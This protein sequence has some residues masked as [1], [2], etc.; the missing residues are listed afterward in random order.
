MQV[1]YV[2]VQIVLVLAVL[3]IIIQEAAHM[4]IRLETVLQTIIVETVQQEMR[5]V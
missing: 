1:K 2:I 4:I 3:V 5:D